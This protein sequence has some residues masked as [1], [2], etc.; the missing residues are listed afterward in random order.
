M[1]D[2]IHPLP[3]PFCGSTNVITSEWFVDEELATRFRSESHEAIAVMECTEC[4]A[5]APVQSWQN[6][7]DPWRYPPEM[8]KDGQSV[9]VI[10]KNRDGEIVG[11]CSHRYHAEY[12]RLYV[13]LVCWTPIPE[14]RA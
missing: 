1:T 9:V 3:C 7:P 2:P 14:V 13:P 5:A 4:L 10:R 12:E 8:P 11:P 6:R